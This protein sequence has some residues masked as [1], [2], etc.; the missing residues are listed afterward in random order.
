MCD[1]CVWC[2]WCVRVCVCVCLCVCVCVMCVCVCLCECACVCVCVCTCVC[3]CV[4]VWRT[5]HSC[6]NIKVR[7]M[8]ICMYFIHVVA[9]SLLFTL[10]Y[11]SYHE[12]Q[13]TLF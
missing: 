1:V 6:N 11:K 12:C 9:S 7:H 5:M 4:C 3:V 10:Q 8:Y 13:P 2:V